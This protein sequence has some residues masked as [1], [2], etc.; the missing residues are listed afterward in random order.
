MNNN[1]KKVIIIICS[2]VCLFI[3]GGGVFLITKHFYENKIEELEEE[4]PNKQNHNSNSEN[5]KDSENKPNEEN[6]EETDFSEAAK[7]YTF[8]IPDVKGL[9]KESAM[10]KITSSLPK[11]TDIK[12]DFEPS[13]AVSSDLPAN[14]IVKTKP[15]IGENIKVK[16]GDTIK[17]TL[18]PSLGPLTVKTENY[19]GK[20]YLEVKAQLES[21]GL[22]VIVEKKDISNSTNY[23]EDTIIEQSIAA[24][25]EVNKGETIKLYIPNVEVKY[26]D[27]TNKE[28]PYTEEDVRKFCDLYNLK[29]EVEYKESSS[30]PGTII[31]QSKPKDYKVVPGTSFKI[32]IAS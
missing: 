8:N 20:N 21:Y 1:N 9:D 23:N 29:L 12:I 10:A 28:N 6:K 17:I 22:I 2:I 7:E 19:I 31:A 18:Y 14:Q 26:P 13:V 27:F 5:E 32:T 3:I 4:K 11:N 24:G 30:A 16:N 25:K 15:A